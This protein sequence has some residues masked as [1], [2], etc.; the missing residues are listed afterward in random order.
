ME[1]G[2]QPLSA[3]TGS[4]EI[5]FTIVSMTLSL[6]RYH[7]VLFDG[8]NPG[9]LFREFQSTICVAM[10]DLRRGVRYSD[11]RCCAAAFLRSPEHQEAILFYAQPKRF[12]DG[13]L[14]LYDRR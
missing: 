3:L 2:E 4:K 11:G 12:F 1:L 14:H 13:M 8:R 7:P 9:R 10:S 5:G 6:A